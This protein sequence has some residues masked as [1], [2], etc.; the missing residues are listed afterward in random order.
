MGRTKGTKNLPKSPEPLPPIVCLACV[1]LQ[2]KTDKDAQCYDCA[3]MTTHS[4]ARI[5]AQEAEFIKAAT[6]LRH[7]RKCE[8]PIKTESRHWLCTECAPDLPEDVLD[9]YGHNKG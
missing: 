8:N 3:S 5:N 1:R 6:V 7:C 2:S 9:A 4:V